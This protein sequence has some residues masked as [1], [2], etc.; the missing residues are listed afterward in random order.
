LGSPYDGAEARRLCSWAGLTPRRRDS[1][2]KV[3]RGHITK[4]GSTLVRWATVE[5]VG[6]QRGPTKIMTDLYSI[7]ERRGRPSRGSPRLARL[8]PSSY[9][10]LRDG[11]IRCLT[12]RPAQ[13]A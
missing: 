5:A 10:G 1:D 12:E 9:Y 13:A 11:N 8:S 6:R 4:Q 3:R 7:A 2:V